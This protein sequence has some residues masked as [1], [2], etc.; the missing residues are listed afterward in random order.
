MK[1]EFST[2]RIRTAANATACAAL[3]SCNVSLVHAQ[4][5]ES[6]DAV[7]SLTPATTDGTLTASGWMGALRS[8]PLGVTGIFQGVASVFASHSG[9]PEG[10]MAMN[11]NNTTDDN[12]IS[13]WAMSPVL[14]MSNGDTFS[15]YTRVPTGGGIFP[16]RLEV[17]RNGADASLDVG[18]TAQSVGDFT[19]LL[20][21]I[22][23]ALTATGYPETW[24]QFSVTIS[25]LTGP[26]PG[27]LGFRYFV[28]NGGPAGANSNYIGIDSFQYSGVPEPH[29]YAL[30]AGLGLIGFAFWHRRTAK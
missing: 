7:T 20:L 19:D 16:D 30:M 26:T 6:F 17:R 11:F 1:I 18:T 3:L 10:Y 15:F 13:T 5:V 22:N 21:T 27:R 12:T 28:E 14:I 9:P 24:T 8:D 25:G 23:P 29:E 4:L 2:C